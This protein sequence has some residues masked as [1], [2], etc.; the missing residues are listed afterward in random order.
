[1][2]KKGP[3]YTARHY[4]KRSV[5]T[6]ISS[7]MISAIVLVVKHPVL[8]IVH[9]ADYRLLYHFN[10][11]GG[12]PAAKQ[13][14]P[15]IRSSTAAAPSPLFRPPTPCGPN[16]G[17]GTPPSVGPYSES[18]AVPAGVRLSAAACSNSTQSASNA[19]HDVLP[20][21]AE[22]ACAGSYGFF[23]HYQFERRKIAFDFDDE[24]G[25]RRRDER[26]VSAGPRLMQC[27][28][29]SISFNKFRADDDARRCQMRSL[30][31][32]ASLYPAGIRTLFSA[33]E[34]ILSR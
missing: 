32:S 22:A 29:C 1:M 18:P 34:T 30:N 13:S 25:G 24:D 33:A 7:S 26:A 21:Q 14:N 5:H 20:S 6:T 17:R 2:E 10:S 23:L 8:R 31:S 19:D 15:M 4:L 28:C 11:F 9:L 16:P 3:S 27:C 12:G